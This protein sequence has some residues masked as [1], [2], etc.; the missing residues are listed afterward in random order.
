MT[1][2][3]K[4]AYVASDTDLPGILFKKPPEPDYFVRT[5]NRIRTCAAEM[6]IAVTDDEVERFSL[7]MLGLASDAKAAIRAKL[8]ERDKPGL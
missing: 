7:I 2:E 6:C 8:G 3:N 1:D 5:Q 4:T